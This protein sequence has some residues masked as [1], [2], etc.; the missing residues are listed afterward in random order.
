[1]ENLTITQHSIELH[2]FITMIIGI[3]AVVIIATLINIRNKIKMLERNNIREKA[4]MLET[5]RELRIATISTAANLKEAT[6][7]TAKH[8]KESTI[9][10]ASILANS[11][12]E[13]Q[14]DTLISINEKLDKVLSD[15][16][17]Q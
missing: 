5:A 11:S 8:L 1:M 2:E 16:L 7:E 12:N 14:C 3:I 15:M 9:K 13:K 17:K 6:V 4:I 10:T